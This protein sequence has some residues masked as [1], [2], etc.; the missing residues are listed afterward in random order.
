MS[1][2]GVTFRW[3]DFLFIE[4]Y[5]GRVAFP[6][7]PPWAAFPG[8]AENGPFGEPTLPNTEATSWVGSALRADRH[9]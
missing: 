5:F 6:T 9:A 3:E 7:R 4:F 1:L 2:P 8:S